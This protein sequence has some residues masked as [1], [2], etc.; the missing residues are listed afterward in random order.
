MSAV[1]PRSLFLLLSLIFFPLVAL[2]ATPTL[3]P[4]RDPGEMGAGGLL[5]RADDGLREAPL[6]ETDVAIEVSGLI[7]R[8][9]VTQR[10]TNPT[11]DWVEGVYVFPLPEDAAVDTLTMRIGERVIAG[12][13]EE[14]ARAKRTYEKAKSE[15]RKASLVEQERPNV[16]TTS[17]ANLGPDETVEVT[18]AYQ[19]DA[20]Y[21]RGRFSLRFPLVVGPRYVPG[22]PIASGFAG[23][24]WGVNTD[25]VPDAARIT[26]PVAKPGDGREHPVT[27]RA[28]IDA[29]FPLDSVSS[30]SHPLRIRAQ[31][32]DV[33]AIGLDDPDAQA[34]RDFVLEWVPA[35]GN[36]PNAALFRESMD[37]DE[38]ALLMVMPPQ[39]ETQATRVSRETII[40]IDTSGSMSGESIVQARRAVREALATLRPEDAFN[41][42]EFDSGFRSLFPEARPATP[43]AVARANQWVE[44]LDAEGGTN[45][46]PALV[47]ALQPGA[48]SRAVRQ[49]VFVTDG[50]VG[51]ERGLFSAIER[52]LGRSRLYTVGIGSAPNGHFMSKAAEFGRGTFTYIGNPAEVVP[53]MAALFEKI[54]SPVLH[55]LHVDWGDPSVESWPA[56]IPDVYAGEPVVV[57]ARLPRE[58][59]RVVVSGK[60]GGEDVRLEL[61]LGGGAD[62]EGVSRL[63]ARRKVAGLMDSLH[64]GRS[65]DEVSAEVA[66]IGVRHQLVTRWSSLVAVDVTPT[67][68][69]DAEPTTRRVPSLLP[70]GWDF[71]KIFGRRGRRE[72][73]DASPAPMAVAPPAADAVAIGQQIA[74]VR[75]GRLPQG[76]TPAALLITLGA[77]GLGL[78]GTLLAFAS[79]RRRD[80]RAEEAG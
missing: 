18:I 28:E 32:G 59:K 49:V 21:D 12:R 52:H 13:V 58:A 19:E 46:L 34:D 79:G 26:P 4:V 47:A 27:V 57:A 78:G 61:D 53:K 41:V 3:G 24:G 10:F 75:I 14:R 77:S 74:S 50:A 71:S 68:P 40:V 29:G 6:L 45:M 69:V 54:D 5:I 2:A 31:R 9:R 38:Y 44:G 33:Y 7:A 48:E 16:F 56:R 37:G 17:I 22:T 36:A 67:A 80:R 1:R 42:I 66:A 51:N 63:W 8:T 11:R 60:R 55:D 72:R 43:E 39:V 73:A 25:E 35:V 64:E 23:T 65:M 20:R 76:G 15:G 30:P 70:A 62:H